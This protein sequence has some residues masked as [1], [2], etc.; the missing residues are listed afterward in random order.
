MLTR[1][2]RRPP[3]AAPGPDGWAATA[4]ELP[5][6]GGARIAVLGLYHAERDT[7]VHM[8]ASGVTPE[9]DWE[10]YRG[11]RPLPSL[12]VQDSRGHWHTRLDAYSPDVDAGEVILR[13]AIVPPLDPG[14]AWIDVVAAG[15][16][17]EV[18]VRLPLCWT[19]AAS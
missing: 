6:L 12:W 11:V 14:T 2:H 10:Y 9:D 19:P 13:L 15:Q 17:T 18:R 8:L 1:Y 4:A 3:Q 7:I 16:S 5:G